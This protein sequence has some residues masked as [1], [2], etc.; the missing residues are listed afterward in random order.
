MARNP[1]GSVLSPFVAGAACVQEGMG[2]AEHG[3]TGYEYRLF[4]LCLRSVIPLPELEPAAH[5]A[6]AAIEIGPGRVADPWQGGVA[7]E[8][9][10][11]TPEGAILTAPGVARFCISGGRRIIVDA[12]PAASDRNVRLYLLGSAMGALL[13]QR[14]ILPLHAN[15]I[16]LD[17]SAVAFL[18]HSGAG[19]STLAAAFHDRGRSVLSDD[20]CALVRAGPTFVAQPGIPR[21]RLW[22]DAV[23]RS[24]RRTDEYERA[25]DTLDKY[26]VGTDSGARATAMPLK[27]IYLL[28]RGADGQDVQIGRLSGVAAVR[29][30]MENT[31]RGN[32]IQKIGDPGGH[33]QACLALVA[34]VPLFALS[35][36]WEPGRIEDT[37]LSVEHHVG[38]PAFA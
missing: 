3:L 13:H 31:Y 17:G 19:K 30:L 37:M 11:A 25:F 16:A 27:A 1:I 4:G 24:G 29:A 2:E 36:P 26:T 20:V 22:R 23:E 8:P 35:R 38:G 32:F 28:L 10:V 6:P 5:G 7:L 34:A 14:S 18:G 9:I 33:L 15:A 21:L 12:D